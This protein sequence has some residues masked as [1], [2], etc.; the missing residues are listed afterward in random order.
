MDW[1]SFMFKL[2]EV[3]GAYFV[4]SGVITF[5]CWQ[6]GKAQKK[7]AVYYEKKDHWIGYFY[8]GAFGGTGRVVYI[9]LIPRFLI[10]IERKGQNKRV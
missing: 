2:V 3:I 5:F 7:Q 9:C 1:G 4:I 6:Y 10:R 8:S